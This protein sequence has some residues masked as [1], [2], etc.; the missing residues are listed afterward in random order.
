MLSK[1]VVKLYSGLLEVGL[2]LMLLIGL[3]G[4]YQSG[5]FFGAI[6][7]VVVAA[8]FGAIIFG[9]FLVLDDIRKRVNEIESK[10]RS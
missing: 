6:I 7:G 3:V 4:G 8:I 10:E 9:A 2:W 1:M 5:G